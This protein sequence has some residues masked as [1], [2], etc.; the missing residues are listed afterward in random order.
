[1]QALTAEP[2]PLLESSAAAAS[3]NSLTARAQVSAC[4]AVACV[5][6]RCSITAHCTTSQLSLQQRTS[7]GRGA[8]CSDRA[9]HALCRLEW[10]VERRGGPQAGEDRA[11]PLLQQDGGGRAVRA[12]AV[13]QN[14]NPC[15]R[16][17]QL[18]PI[19]VVLRTAGALKGDLNGDL[20]G[21]VQLPEGRSRKI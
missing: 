8:V 6:V 20:E 3:A 21:D 18:C 14:L 7:L 11:P 16:A 13:T 4:A 9:V 17:H 1:M 15:S 19:R 2:M 5:R 12:G 10:R